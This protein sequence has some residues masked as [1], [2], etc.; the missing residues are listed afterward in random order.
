MQGQ[1]INEHTDKPRNIEE[2]KHIIEAAGS[3][4]IRIVHYHYLFGAFCFFV[5]IMC[6]LGSYYVQI[7]LNIRFIISCIALFMPFVYIKIAIFSPEIKELRAVCMNITP[8]PTPEKSKKGIVSSFK[9]AA[10]VFLVFIVA[11]AIAE[12]IANIIVYRN[13][14]DVSILNIFRVLQGLNL[15]LYVWV[16]FSDYATTCNEEYCHASHFLKLNLILSIFL[17][18]ILPNFVVP[19]ISKK[20]IEFKSTIMV[21]GIVKGSGDK[22]ENIDNLHSVFDE[23]TCKPK[24]PYSKISCL[25]IHRAHPDVY[26]LELKSSLTDDNSKQLYSYHRSKLDSIQKVLRKKTKLHIIRIQKADPK[27]PTVKP[28]PYLSYIR[29]FPPVIF[30]MVGMGF[31]LLLNT[32]YGKYRIYLLF[33]S[34]YIRSSPEGQVN[35]LA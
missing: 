26:E 12:I 33:V 29:G 23:F 4:L 7:S 14:S 1:T 15:A 6:L 34:K 3:K 32:L 21:T 19:F 10:V 11:N 8:D 27:T 13:T 9:I 16:I 2:L 31:S 5:F 25:T 17:M 22:A 24:A 18:I 20:N 35:N 28:I 30:S